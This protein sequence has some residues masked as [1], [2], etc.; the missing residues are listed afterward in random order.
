MERKY[1]GFLIFN[2][3]TNA[4][5]IRHK[6]PKVRCFEVAIKYKVILKL[7]DCPV[8]TMDMGTIEIPNAIVESTEMPSKGEVNG[9]LGSSNKR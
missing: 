8:P 1:S 2:W 7:P 6:L 5:R 4:T 3:Q 9:I